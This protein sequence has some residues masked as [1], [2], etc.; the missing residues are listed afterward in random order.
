[1]GFNLC[2]EDLGDLDSLPVAS[3]EHEILL[4]QQW[5]AVTWDV[6]WAILDH[7]QVN[8]L[9]S[10]EGFPGRAAQLLHKDAGQVQHGLNFMESLAEVWLQVCRRNEPVV[11]GRAK[12][13]FMN[14]A[15]A[16]HI[17]KHLSFKNFKEV[18]LEVKR[19]LQ[20]S[21]AMGQTRLQEKSFHRIRQK[22]TKG[23]KKKG[24]APVK[25]WLLPVQHKT[26]SKE[27]QYK[28]IDFRSVSRCDPMVG[29]KR[30]LPSSFFMPRKKNLPVLQEHQWK[31]PIG[32]L[33]NFHCHEPVQAD[34]RHGCLQGLLQNWQMER[35]AALLAVLPG[36]KRHC[37]AK[38]GQH[39]WPLALL[40][41]CGGRFCHQD[42]ACQASGKPGGSQHAHLH[43]GHRGDHS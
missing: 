5:V 39:S 41:W 8:L 15:A 13:S 27:Y 33:A 34:L 7:R 37:A 18:P 10:W 11:Q 6:A 40:C 36:T 12:R 4:E 16:D 30:K 24:L 31:E 35:V 42:L 32:A 26:A 21:F 43:P 38:E 3:L 20:A 29:R 2:Q 28:E 1:M 14:T 25:R 23:Q 22:E 17:F 9:S 19:C